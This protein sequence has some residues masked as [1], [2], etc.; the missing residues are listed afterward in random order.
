[1]HEARADPLRGARRRA[2]LVALL[3]GRMSGST[4]N[5]TAVARTY[6]RIE[7]PST[8]ETSPRQGRMR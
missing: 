4:P 2:A 1:M 7:G 3:R 6:S 8:I 5:S